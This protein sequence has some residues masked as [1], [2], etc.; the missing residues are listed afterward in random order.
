MGRLWALGRSG[1]AQAVTV[2]G[3][4]H[5]GSASLNRGFSQGRGKW[6]RGCRGVLLPYTKNDV[7]WETALS[8]RAKSRD[9][10]AD[11]QPQLL[12]TPLSLLLCM[13]L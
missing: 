9:V 13:G 11:Q 10:P 7:P 1:M 5:S 4:I 2:S 3:R 6:G 8:I 12:E